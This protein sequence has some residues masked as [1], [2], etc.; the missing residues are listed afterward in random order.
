MCDA[1]GKKRYLAFRRTCV[2]GCFAV[3]LEK[4]LFLFRLEILCHFVVYLINIQ[5]LPNLFE[6]HPAKEAMLEIVPSTES[7]AKLEIIFE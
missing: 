2:G 1:I 4:L 7:G 6:S 5:E 3:L